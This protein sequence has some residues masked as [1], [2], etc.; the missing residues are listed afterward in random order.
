[1]ATI[2]AGPHPVRAPGG[3]SG[4]SCYPAPVIDT[5]GWVLLGVLGVMAGSMVTLMMF[6]VTSLRGEMG[7]LRGEMVSLRGEMGS[8]RNE[9]NVRFDGVEHRLDG[10]DRDVQA[11]TE[12][13]FPRDT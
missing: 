6:S 9:M 8:L 2:L 13:V 12:R 4:V 10:L 11:F 1:M 7:S 5:Q 3:A